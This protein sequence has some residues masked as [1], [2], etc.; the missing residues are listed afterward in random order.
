LRYLDK[1]FNGLMPNMGS[2]GQDWQTVFPEY[3]FGLSCPYAHLVK[4]DKLISREEA[5]NGNPC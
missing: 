5:C 1:L 2:I 4:Q 3:L